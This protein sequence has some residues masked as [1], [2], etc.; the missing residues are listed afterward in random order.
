MLDF[1]AP[2][3]KNVQKPEGCRCRPKLN[4]HE[5]KAYGVPNANFLSCVMFQTVNGLTSD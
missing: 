2:A 4:L 5:A 3:I 1:H